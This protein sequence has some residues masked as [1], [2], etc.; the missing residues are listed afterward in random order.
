M[1]ISNV[2]ILT[3]TSCLLSPFV[4]ESITIFLRDVYTGELTP[5][6]ASEV[7]SIDYRL[8]DSVLLSTSPTSSRKIV[9]YLIT[10]G[11]VSLSP[12]SSYVVD[13]D[14][15][16]VSIQC[17]SLYGVRFVSVYI[18]LSMVLILI[19]F[20]LVCGYASLVLI[21]WRNTF[22]LC[23]PQTINVSIPS[24]FAHFCAATYR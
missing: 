4:T 10:Y 7:T 9:E 2:T 22:V 13:V 21:L 20:P 6:I 17:L 24:T 1:P 8:L 16:L 18:V 14:A 15:L 3:F 12:V 5:H 19:A 11:T 23:F